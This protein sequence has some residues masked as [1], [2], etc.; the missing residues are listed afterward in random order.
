MAYRRIQVPA[1]VGASHFFALHSGLDV[2]YRGKVHAALLGQCGRALLRVSQ[3][4]PAYEGEDVL[5]TEESVD[6]HGR[7]GVC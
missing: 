6:K 1:L 4:C 2:G 5:A 7:M 3:Y